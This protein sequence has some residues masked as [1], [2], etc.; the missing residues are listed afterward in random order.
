MNRIHPKKLR[1]SKWTAVKPVRREKHF[2]VAEVEF[3]DDRNVISCVLQA[4]LSKREFAIEWR[5]LTD[6]SRWKQGWV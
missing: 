2:L 4:V 6:D 5:E 1:N 3:D